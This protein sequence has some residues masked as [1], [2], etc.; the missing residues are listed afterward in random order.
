MA[1][2]QRTDKRGGRGRFAGSRP[3]KNHGKPMLTGA[4]DG[5]TL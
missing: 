2:A 4:L 5:S 3:S 1:I